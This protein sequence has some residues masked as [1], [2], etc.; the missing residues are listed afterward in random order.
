LWGMLS[1]GIEVADKVAE[2][3]PEVIVLDV[4]LGMMSGFEVTR[5]LKAWNSTA[6]VVFFSVQQSEEFVSA[7]VFPG[8]LGYVFKS[9]G[10][11]EMRKAILA[12]YGGE[13]FFPVGQG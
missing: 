11:C 2:L 13:K 12:A 6:R 5:R 10:D 7:A 1:S 8:A 3:M 9:E 4:S